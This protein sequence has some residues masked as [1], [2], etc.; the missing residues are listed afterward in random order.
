MIYILNLT[1]IPF[2]VSGVM[3]GS[4][5]E[6]EG[7]IQLGDKFVSVDG[8]L[9]S[10]LS[11]EAVMNEMEDSSSGHVIVLTRLEEDTE[12]PPPTPLAPPPTLPV[13]APPD[14][15]S[16]EPGTNV[17]EDEA[18]NDFDGVV[19]DSENVELKMERPTENVDSDIKASEADFTVN[20]PEN[21]VNSNELEK[22]ESNLTPDSISVTIPD[23]AEVSS[24]QGSQ[25]S[26]VDTQDSGVDT[27]DSGVDSPSPLGTLTST[28]DSDA[29]ERPKVD[30]EEKQP[31]SNGDRN[32]G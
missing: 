26:G 25:D 3:E 12:A 2:Q 15:P 13:S 5:A 18:C 29:K 28:E 7:H 24:P 23:L 20:G 8:V 19:T 14:V 6:R 21:S 1:N 27:Q 11:P 10:S 30:I 31:L 22:H 32:Q 9:A 17:V 16:E 4:L